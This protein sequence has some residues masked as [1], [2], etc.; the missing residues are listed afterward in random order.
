MRRVLVV[1]IVVLSLAVS[2][3]VWAA[4]GCPRAVEA[5]SLRGGAAASSR[6]RSLHEAFD[7][8]EG[9]GSASHVELLT[10]PAEAWGARWEML[11]S[12][13][14]RVD[15]AYYIADHDVIG[16]AFLGELSLL[17]R[18]GVKV[19]LLV[20]R[21]GSDELLRPLAGRDWLEELAATDNAVVY[22]YNP[23]PDA[24]AGAA[25]TASLLPA[26][27]ST[28]K[29]LL[30]VDETVAITGGRNLSARYFSTADEVDDGFLDSDVRF[31]GRA[32]VARAMAEIDAEIL[33][34]PS[35]VLTPDAVNVSSRADS[36]ALIAAA[37]DAWLEGR[38]PLEPPAAVA[39]LEAA[40]VRSLDEPPSPAALDDA[41]PSFEELVKLPSLWGVLPLDP[42]ARHRATV[43]LVS[44][45]SLAN[46][47]VATKQTRAIED[48]IVTALDGAREKIV[49]ESPYLVLT[50]RL[51][52]AF[53]QAS[54]RGVPIVVLT[55]GPESSDNPPS[56]ALFIDTWP[57]L[58]ARLPT[59]RLF[60]RKERPTLHAKR[61]VIDDEL[62]LIGTY[63]LDPLSARLNSEV[64]LGVWSKGF[65]AENRREIEGRIGDGAS[66]EYRIERDAAGRAVRHPAGH[67]RAGR[68]V[69]IFG[70]ADHTPPAR[71]E[72]L[73]AQKAPLLRLAGAAGMDLVAW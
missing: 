66:V 1:G 26:L 6:P 62:T 20:D 40:A 73:A 34:S 36:L 11:R 71:L 4:A 8:I 22:V 37:M 24:V 14:E 5:P 45:Q 53:E 47:P 33:R 9:T 55:N 15:A 54:A 28:H 31:D 57:E 35:D 43:R 18:R 7:R 64:V 50:P 44:E 65:A 69:V 51:L 10:S 67:P 2:L 72:L 12:A 63:N 42:P 56:Q 16:L 30:A 38:V 27:A 70:P 52:A 21:R 58:M 48:A 61:F 60:V 3:S 32:L 49:V 23:A 13:Q 46:G 17:A 39:A 41:R 29:K 59:L 25:A 68:V 19:R